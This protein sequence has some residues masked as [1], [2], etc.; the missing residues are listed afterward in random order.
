MLSRDITTSAPVTCRTTPPV[1]PPQWLHPAGPTPTDSRKFGLSHARPPLPRISSPPVAT[2]PRMF[3]PV[4]THATH[5]RK[6]APVATHP[7]KF[8]PVAT[9]PRKSAPIATH[10]RKS[11]PVATHP[12]KSAPVASPRSRAPQRP[13][14]RPPAPR[15]G[16]H[17]KA[18]GRE[19]G[20]TCNSPTSP[21]SHASTEVRRRSHASTEVRP[22]S[23]ASGR[24]HAR[25]RSRA[26]PRPHAR[27][28][29]PQRPRSRALTQ[30]CEAASSAARATRQNS[31]STPA[32]GNWV[33]GTARQAQGIVCRTRR[34]CEG[35]A[36]AGL[37][38]SC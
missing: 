36:G 30:K 11:A 15:G 14:A 5:P 12:R 10:P 2:H 28:P 16:P 18:R 9:H 8:A 38:H 3:A 34:L 25:T 7:R 19:F 32:A 22:R 33:G 17:A 13:H 31:L 1:T 4:A 21:R 27:L 24:S 6:F 35:C 23:H 26:S 37:A 20:H 29:A